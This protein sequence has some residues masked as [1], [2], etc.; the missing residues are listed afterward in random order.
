[1]IMVL[2]STYFEKVE[3][4][5]ERARFPY[6]Q[7][8]TGWC[9]AQVLESRTDMTGKKCNVDQRPEFQTDAKM[10]G[11]GFSWRAS[12]SSSSKSILFPASSAHLHDSGSF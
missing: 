9:V 11:L 5:N 8:S 6:R 3:L 1:M 4:V 10:G 7:F 2:C 12:Q